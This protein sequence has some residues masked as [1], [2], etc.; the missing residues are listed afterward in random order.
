MSKFVTYVWLTLAPSTILSLSSYAN[1]TRGAPSVA[2]A[3]IILKS[4][5]DSDFHSSINENFIDVKEFERGFFRVCESSLEEC[6]L[7]K[8]YG[9]V[10]V[11]AFDTYAATKIPALA[12]FVAADFVVSSSDI[13]VRRR[14]LKLDEMKDFAIEVTNT[15]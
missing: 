4:R 2:E 11:S 9:S 7:I 3:K 5:I 6:D 13:A 12:L 8:K 14:S 1:V 15:W 10:W